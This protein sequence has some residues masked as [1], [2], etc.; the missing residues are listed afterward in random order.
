MS[1]FHLS[2]RG[3]SEIVKILENP[4]YGFSTLLAV[5]RSSD[6]LTSL[7]LSV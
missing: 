7:L 4:A 3:V 6:R 1:G 5:C 2:F